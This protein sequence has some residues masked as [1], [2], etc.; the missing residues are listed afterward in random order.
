M[1]F[2][3][4]LFFFYFVLTQCVPFLFQVHNS[5]IDITRIAVHS[6]G[7]ERNG[8][9]LETEVGSLEEVSNQESSTSL[10]EQILD[11]TLGPPNNQDVYN[12]LSIITVP[13]GKSENFNELVKVT[14]SE[15]GSCAIAFESTFE[16]EKVDIGEKPE[17]IEVE[18]NDDP[19]IKYIKDTLMDNNVD[20]SNELY[21][22]L[23]NRI[24]VRDAAASVA[25]MKKCLEAGVTDPTVLKCICSIATEE[26]CIVK[27]LFGGYINSSDS[28]EYI[29]NI[30]QKQ[31]QDFEDNMSR[32][33]S[34]DGNEAGTQRDD[35]EKV[36][37]QS[38][39]FTFLP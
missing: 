18:D 3:P 5:T 21:I 38:A 7:D 36:T 17:F 2:A 12:E 37:K 8:N 34:H 1:P 13:C 11:A 35:V 33:P 25:L 23:N 16:V 39:T 26:D 19:H 29:M 28:N 9:F 31:I 27:H 22:T 32:D 14:E 6:T 20:F 30:V 24:V 15:D 10:I 4:K